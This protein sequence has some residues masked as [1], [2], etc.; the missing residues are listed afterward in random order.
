[1]VVLQR[2]VVVNGSTVRCGQTDLYEVRIDHY[3]KLGDQTPPGPTCCR[4]VVCHSEARWIA[5]LMNLENRGMV[6]T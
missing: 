2:L 5:R 1:M 6:I 3:P 4:A